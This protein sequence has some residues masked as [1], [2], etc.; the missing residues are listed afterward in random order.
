MSN[1]ERLL[2]TYL[3]LIKIN[4]VSGNEKTLAEYIARKLQELGLEVQWSY[5][6]E[7]GQSSPSLLTRLRGSASGPNLLL[8]GHMDTV[9]VA[10]GWLT[11]PFKPEI[12]ED[13]VLGLGAMDMKGGIAAILE[14]LHILREEETE[15]A[16]S[17]TA[18][19]IS[20]EELISRGT[21]RLLQDGLSADM[22]IMAECR[23]NEVAIGFRGRYSISV[24]VY[25]K[26]AHSRDYPTVGESAVINAAKIALGIEQLPTLNHPALG[27]GT[28]CVRH[29]SGGIKTTLS[30]PDQCELF[31]DRYVV[32]GETF[33]ICSSQIMTLARSLGLQ[34]KVEVQL[35]PRPTPYME[36]FEI[37]RNHPLVVTLQEKYRQVTGKEL[38]LG[39]DKSVCDSNFL[40]TLGNIPTVTFGPSGGNMHGANEHGSITQI[41]QSVQIYVDTVKSLLAV[42]RN[43]SAGAV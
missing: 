37:D 13:I 18:A 7:D 15:W 22:A 16:G 9:D 20:D 40:V 30:V 28:W 1:S 4:S 34:D 6:A 21:H 8:I 19:F 38:P 41:K 31:V 3:E 11:D 14:T 12:R 39:Y 2:D 17:I 27:C 5:F 35:V 43:A 24:K 32:P 29:I 23:F 42:G 25:G 26:A 33:E 36:A 10:R